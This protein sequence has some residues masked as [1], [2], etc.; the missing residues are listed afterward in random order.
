MMDDRLHPV[1]SKTV[2][3]KRHDVVTADVNLP[4]KAFIHMAALLFEYAALE[5]NDDCVSA[6]TR[7]EFCEDTLHVALNG[8]H[9]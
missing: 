2:A 3:A 4:D 5:R 6:I 1:R 8:M 7:F 9:R